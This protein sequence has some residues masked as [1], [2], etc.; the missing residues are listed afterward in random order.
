MKQIWMIIVVS[1]LATTI[2]VSQTPFYKNGVT[3]KK[4]FLDYQSQNGG[5]LTKFN[6][7]Q[8]GYEIGFQ[9]ILSD[10]I[11]IN[12]PFRYGIVDSHLDS[13][14]CLKKRVLSLDAAL[15]YHFYKEAR[16]ITP[17]LLG[18]IGGVYENEGDFNL[19]IPL[20]LGFNV[21][22]APNAFINWQSEYRIG[23][24]EERT[25]LQHGL[26]FIYFFGD[27][28]ESPL[29][30]VIIEKDSDNDGIPD[31]LDLC[32]SI[33]GE[34]NLNG[35]PDTDGDGIAN[36]LDKCP[37]IKGLEAFEG[38]PDTDGDGVSDNMDQCPNL[39]GLISN[40]GCPSVDKDGDGVND[41]EDRCPDL[42][43]PKENN[44]CPYSDADGDGI[45]DKDDKCPN[46]YGIRIYNGC[47]D[48]DNDGIDD[49]RD[50]CPNTAGTVANDGC[51]EIKI[52][53]KKTLEIAMK[54]VQFQTGSAVLKSESNAIL[55]Q[56]VDIMQRYRDFNMMISGHTDNVGSAELNQSLSEKR[57]KAC[58]D[59]LV[60]NGISYSRLSH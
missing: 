3:V 1:L 9:R 5:T 48:T 31:S 57:A 2:S 40:N 37:E 23:L 8:H 45:A 4:M 18:G 28:K 21:K 7:Y 52:E 30:E 43:G 19:Q 39:A 13:I 20:G 58:Y 51:P 56:I 27:K 59:F 44:G 17:Y 12:L 34:K 47:P 14:D 11:S 50:K 53:D 60:K 49:S 32:P 42:S 24:K 36:H 6:D 41:S 29:P 54:A 35:C 46:N 33:F 22:V 10:K 55:N 26:G 25:N 38:C 15:Q 16:R